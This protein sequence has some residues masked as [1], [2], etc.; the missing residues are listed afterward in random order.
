M[1]ATTEPNMKETEQTPINM[2][3]ENQPPKT[4]SKPNAANSESRAKNQGA[5]GSEAAPKKNMTHD[6]ITEEQVEDSAHN[7]KR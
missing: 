7:T 1:V 2:G 5:S 6:V 3:E 4:I